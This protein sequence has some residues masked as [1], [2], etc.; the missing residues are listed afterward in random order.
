M[1]YALI[2]AAGLVVAL[3]ATQLVLPPLLASK[4]EDR[5]T[6]HGG[7]ADVDL[8]AV[9]ALRLLAHDGDRF[10]LHGE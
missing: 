9:P 5:L 4:V 7:R 8:D 6:A 10:E 3:V 1:R 2:A